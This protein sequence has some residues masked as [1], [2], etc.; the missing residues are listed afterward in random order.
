MIGK[1]KIPPAH[2]ALRIIEQHLSELRRM[3]GIVLMGGVV[4]GEG[5]G[6]RLLGARRLYRRF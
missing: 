6:A 2:I 1:V 4:R 3:D 5:P